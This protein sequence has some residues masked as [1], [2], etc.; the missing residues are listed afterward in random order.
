MASKKRGRANGRERD[1]FKSSRHGTPAKRA[2]AAGP[3]AEQTRAAEREGA[4]AILIYSDPAHD[5]FAKGDTFP[6][7][8]WGPSSHI[9]RGSITYDFMIAGD[10]LTPGYASLPGYCRAFDVAL[11]PF[12]VSELTRNAN[13]L[14]AREYLAAGRR[15]GDAFREFIGHYDIAMTAVEVK[16]LIEDRAK[17]EIEVTAVLPD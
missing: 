14:K 17:V 10:P 9:Q 2:S 13:P 16:A 5:G 1:G 6:V 3:K 11:V 15:I 7:G 8:P 12:R 4:A